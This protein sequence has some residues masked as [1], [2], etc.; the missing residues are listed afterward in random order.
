MRLQKAVCLPLL[1]CKDGGCD[2]RPGGALTDLGCYLAPS[3]GRLV[4]NLLGP[5][6]F[7]SRPPQPHSLRFGRG[8]PLGLTRAS[9]DGDGLVVRA[10][11]R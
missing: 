8:V 5:S 1:K 3:G 11:A 6:L 4:S 7:R 10:V 9:L 2:L